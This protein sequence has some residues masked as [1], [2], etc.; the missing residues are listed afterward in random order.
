[1][2]NRLLAGL[3][4]CLLMQTTLAEITVST[5]TAP[6]SGSGGLAV[7]VNGHI[8]VADF[9]QTLAGPPGRIV[10]RVDP[11]TGDLSTFADGFRTATGNAFDSKGNLF[12]SNALIGIVSKVDSQGNVS[13]FTNQWLDTPIGIAV[14]SADNVYIASCGTEHVRVVTPDGLISI[15]FS[16][17]ERFNCPQGLA[18]DENDTLYMTNSNDG[19]VFSIDGDGN[20]TVLT[21]IPGSKGAPIICLIPGCDP[22]GPGGPNI[23]YLTY[24]NGRLYVAARGLNQIYEVLLDGTT[25]LLAG[26]GERGNT[27]GPADQ[28]TFSLPNGIDASPDGRFLYVNDSLARSEL[29]VN[30]VVVRVIDLGPQVAEEFA[31]NEGIS[32]SWFPGD[33]GEGWLIEVLSV[34]TVKADGAKVDGLAVA[35]WF[36]FPPEGK[37]LNRKGVD[38][39]QAWIVGV[40]SVQ[41]NTITFEDAQIT[42]GGV[43]GPGFDP[44]TVS[45]A[46]WGDF[47]MT[48]DDCGMGTM[49]Y[50]AKGGGEFGAGE[51]AMERITSV[52]GLDCEALAKKLPSAKVTE[53]DASF[54]GSWFDPTHDGEGWLI[55]V[56]SGGI[57]VVYWFS[58]DGDG[59][60]AWFVGVGSI[61]G[62]TITVDDV[63]IAG[64]GVFGPGFDSDDVELVPW[65]SME[66]TFDSCGTGT[67]SYVS[68]KGGEF[69]SGSLD[70]ERITG[71]AGV[72]CTE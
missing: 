60:Q 2:R 21:E 25:T 40:G 35:Y 16:I 43:F 30:P 51:L 4:A 62:K 71:L 66:F 7:N 31:V 9:G 36:T 13:F 11:V 46:I 68:T 1:M 33:A 61:D 45:H 8:F 19:L 44:G 47:T 12:Q 49:S 14:D 10:T 24:A 23:G 50:A 59:N 27:D 41:G 32:G 29:D 26:T 39:E 58:Y 54:S 72:P 20:A 64:G 52:D 63:F 55:E 15:P 22:L 48:F 17:D 56:L 3:A 53:I 57:A 37:D 70:L 65:G 5:L 34:P 42:S 69:G 38:P 28:A 6:F 18:F 67:M